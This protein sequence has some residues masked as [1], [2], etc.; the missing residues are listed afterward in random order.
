MDSGLRK[1]ES[2]GLKDETEMHTGPHVTN[3][4]GASAASGYWLHLTCDDGAAVIVW[5]DSDSLPTYLVRLCLE[6]AGD[7]HMFQ[8]SNNTKNKDK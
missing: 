8:V 2:I 3:L 5:Q 7:R 4:L 6:R 1:R